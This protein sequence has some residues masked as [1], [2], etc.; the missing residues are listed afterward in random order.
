MSQESRKN[1]LAD[2]H[3]GGELE[4]SAWNLLKQT[5]LAWWRDNCARMGASL[6]YY[7]VFSTAPLLVFAVMIVGAIYGNAAAEGQI[8]SELAGVMG[9]EAAG[10]VQAMV[11]AVRHDQS[12]PLATVLS[13]GALLFGASAAFGELRYALNIIWKVRPKPSAHWWYAVRD[14]LLI[15]LL[16]LLV[17]FLFLAMLVASSALSVAWEYVSAYVPFSNRAARWINYGVTMLVET[18]L[19]AVIFKYLPDGRIAWKDIW[20]GAFVTSLLFGVGNTLISLYFG[21]STMASAY[22]AA[23][24][25][26]IFMLWAYYSAQIVYLG[27]EFTQVYA[28]MYGSRIRPASYA[29][30]VS[31]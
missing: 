22:A 9:Q 29:E 25:L 28:R 1:E 30:R 3:P 23:G 21:H 2:S 10:G 12:G 27:A 8:A 26:A 15:F 6:A 11:S 7:A 24:S 4:P 14:R 19:F 17:G 18:I 31:R 16:V 13:L 5:L 20:L